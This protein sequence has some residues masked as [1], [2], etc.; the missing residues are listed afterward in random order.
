MKVWITKYALTQGILEVEGVLSNI[1]ENT[2]VVKTDGMS[3]C[4]HKPHWHTSEDE[5]KERTLKM[6]ALKR[7]SLAEQL[8]KLD[9]LEQ[10]MEETR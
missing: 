4:Y 5:A 6:I 2:V 8:T 10:K 1:S 3:Q 7:M 9:K